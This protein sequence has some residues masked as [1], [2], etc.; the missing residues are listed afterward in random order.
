MMKKMRLC[1]CLLLVVLLLSSC[2]VQPGGQPG[3]QTTD[4]SVTTAPADTTPAEPTPRDYLPTGAYNNKQVNI[5]L[6]SDSKNEFSVEEITGD[7]VG[8]AVYKRNREIEKNL[9]VQ[10]NY[11]D[12]EG[13]Y[14]NRQN[15]LNT[16]AASI[17]SNT[18]E[19]DICASAANYMLTVASQ[20][21][22]Y[23]LMS[24]PTIDLSQPWWSQGY[25]ENMQVADTLYLATGSAALNMIENLC[26]TYFNKALITDFDLEN[27]YDLVKSGKWTFEKMIEM[28]A[29]VLNDTTGDGEL[30]MEDR[31]GFYTYGNMINA[32]I[33]SFGLS[34]CTRDS[35]GY[36]QVA[37]LNER[38]VSAYEMIY[39][40]YHSKE[41]FSHT[42][43]GDTNEKTRAMEERFTYGNILFMQQCLLSAEPL[44]KMEK[45]FGILP[46]PK[47]DETQDR[48]Y[49][50]S[51]EN[52][53]VL[54]IPS[55]ARDEELSGK[56]IESLAILGHVDV[57]P[58]YFE[59]ALK[60][61]TSR[62]AESREML[63]LILES[64]W[65]DFFYLNS[66]SLDGINHL[67]RQNLNS[68]DSI[69]PP[70]EA[71]KPVLETKLAI[72]LEGYR[73]LK[74]RN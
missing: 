15:Y 4:A 63:D 31:L 38:I 57:V 64:T 46:M 37:N 58:N 9:G 14:S 33:Q 22:F 12:I 39:N 52:L 61:Q 35:E 49:A 65:F 29:T 23:D 72:L 16:I 10:L 30:T 44:R 43:S 20:G 1:A 8:D 19:F 17:D 56:V 73:A 27:P 74:E 41:M 28:S 45:D 7:R 24:N 47:M 71:K 3:E 66:P 6:R 60:T 70:Y 55:S 11:I 62:D 26:V 21:Y 50:C 54:G 51:M 32:Q 68:G 18:G 69:V 13:T 53:T 59:V 40:A 5:L 36:P 34:Y 48:Y 25:V 2:G 67:F 42:G